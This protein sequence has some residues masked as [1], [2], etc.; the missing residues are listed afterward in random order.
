MKSFRIPGKAHRVTSRVSNIDDF[1]KFV[2]RWTVY[3][4]Y[5]KEED[6]QLTVNFVLCSVLWQNINF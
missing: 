1:D 4:F 5:S 2:D 6:Y 3:D